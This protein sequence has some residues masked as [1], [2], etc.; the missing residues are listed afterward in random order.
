MLRLLKSSPKQLLLREFHLDRVLKQIEV[1]LTSVRY[2]YL[3]RGQYNSLTSGHVNFFESFLDKNQVLQDTSEVTGYNIDWMRTVRGSSSLVL[4]P[5]TTE[6]VSNILA[7]CNKERLAVCPQ[8]GNTGLVGGSVPVFDEVVLSLELM[9]RILSVDEITGIA[10]AEAGCVLEKLETELAEANL[11]LPLDLGAKGSCQIGG[12]VS[13]NAGGIRLLRYGNL[14]GSVLGVEAVLS[15]GSVLDCLSTNKKDNTGYD[16]KQLFIGSEGTL[17]VVTRVALQCP[18]KPSSVQVAFLGV[19]DFGQALETMRR[20]KGGLAEI[21]SSCELIDRSAL[22][23]VTTNLALRSPIDDHAFYVLL[24]T[25][26][27]DADH[28]AEKLNRLL[29]QLLHQQ[30]VSDGTVAADATQVKSLWALRER[31]AEALGR[32]GYVYKYDVSV[33]TRKFY[34]LVDDMRLRL[35]DEAVRCCGYG[36]LGD[37]NLHLNVTS[38]QFSRPLL[39]RIEPFIYEWVMAHGG[40][41]SAEHGLGLKKRDFIGYSKSPSAIKWMKHIK[42]LFDPHQILNPYKVFP[43]AK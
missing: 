9:N 21:L 16:L 20:A 19:R 30:I 3:K 1:E 41:V 6:Q 4:R 23:C 28:D 25:A 43:D 32:D 7:Y 13:T 29:E 12:N 2:P 42:G 35:G 24:E 8:G 40:S 5:R 22:D 11:A 37:G 14:H 27:S 26:G 38:R 33:P 15:D 17:G 18:A 34:Q 31:I 10:I 36:H 39:E